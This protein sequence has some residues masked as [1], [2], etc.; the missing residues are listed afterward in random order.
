[1]TPNFDDQL[2][3]AL[4]LFGYD[5]EVIDNPA[6]VDFLDRER[7]RDV[8]IVHV[9]G[10][11]RHYDCRNLLPEIKANARS[12]GGMRRF[13][14]QLLDSHRSPVVLGYS[15]WEGDVIMSALSEHLRRRKRFGLPNKIYWFCYRRENVGQP[16]HL[17]PERP[18]RRV[19]GA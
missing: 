14:A 2:S 9:H 6:T 16:S 7:T 4:R 12:R 17:A 10:T 11:Y 18:L 5:A 3:R 15:G 8:Q 1:M 19:R 13:L